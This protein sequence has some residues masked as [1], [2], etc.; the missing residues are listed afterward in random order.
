M[1]EQKIEQFWRDATAADIAKAMKGEKVEARFRD[2]DD[3]DW[4]EV[5]RLGGFATSITHPISW[6]DV[7]GV[8]WF[9]CQV[10]DPPQW[11]IDKP[12]PGEGYRLLEKFPYEGVEENDQFFDRD[13]W[14]PARLHLQQI[15][16]TWY[17]RRIEP[18]QEKNDC[19][20]FKLLSNE[21][22]QI[23]NGK[24]FKVTQEGFE[25]L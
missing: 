21:V 9:Q 7:G 15:H 3:G 12:D 19:G 11:Y 8:R 14:L 5:D 20:V 22:I 2:Y 23:P 18:K 4:T 24:R 6:F 10:Y 25:V 16:G 1:T 13:I 17:R